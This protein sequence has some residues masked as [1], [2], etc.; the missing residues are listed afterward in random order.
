MI[1]VDDVVSANMFIANSHG[2]NETHRI[3]NVGSGTAVSNNEILKVFSER[4]YKNVTHAPERPGDVR[5]TLADIRR[6]K[7]L[8]WEPKIKFDSGLKSVLDYWEL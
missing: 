5:H 7:A 1:H 6:I 4:G 2:T 8:G 3:F